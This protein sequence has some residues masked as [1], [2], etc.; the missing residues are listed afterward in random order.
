MAD[1]A[2]L[3]SL[4]TLTLGLTLVILG[5]DEAGTTSNAV[6]HYFTWSGNVSMLYPPR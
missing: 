6:T 3:R 5:V 4:L 2:M 1:Q